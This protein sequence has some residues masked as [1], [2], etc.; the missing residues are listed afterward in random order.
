MNWSSLLTNAP[1]SLK[2]D[3]DDACFVCNQGGEVLLCDRCDRVYHLRC[4][5]VQERQREPREIHKNIIWERDI[6]RGI[7]RS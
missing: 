4:L 1:L 2:G 6:E 7:E 3:H 5:S